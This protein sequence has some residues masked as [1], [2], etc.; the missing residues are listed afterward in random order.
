MNNPLEKLVIGFLIGDDELR[1][2]S[3]VDDALRDIIRISP[4]LKILSPVH[5][6]SNFIA[7][8]A[9]WWVLRKMIVLIGFQFTSDETFARLME[10]YEMAVDWTKSYMKR[11]QN[12]E[13][14]Y[15][16]GPDCMGCRV[17]RVSACSKKSW[18]GMA[19]ETQI[20][21]RRTYRSRGTLYLKSINNEPLD[22]NV[23]LHIVCSAEYW[24]VC[25]FGNFNL[26]R[27]FKEQWYGIRSRDGAGRMN[28]CLG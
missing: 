11:V 16:C 7:L 20:A 3:Q 6:N 14:E 24:P 13:V 26:G 18:N 21:G 15:S 10:K 2:G 25:Q 28:Y 1:D 4:M 27:F 12:V 23:S 5:P 19:G 17:K 8:T 22:W 9:H